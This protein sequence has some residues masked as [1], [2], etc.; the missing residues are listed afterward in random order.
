MAVDS[1]CPDL[2]HLQAFVSGTL[3]QTDRQVLE[4]HLDHCDDCL[5][6]LR[7]LPDS[8]SA[9]R[10]ASRA[11]EPPPSRLTSREGSPPQF[12]PDGDPQRARTRDVLPKVASPDSSRYPF[13]MPAVEPDELGRL[14]NYRVLRLV[15]AGGMGMVFQAEDIALRRPVALK[16]MRPELD[17][18]GQSWKRFLREA[19]T[20]ARIKH[21]HLV[22]VYQ[23][24]QEGETIY[25]AMELLEGETLHEWLERTRPV[26]VAEILRLGREIASGL[27]AIHRQGLVHRDIKPANLWLEGTERRVKI[28]DFGLARG[29]K[30]DTQLTQ[31]GTIMGTPAFMAPEQARGGPVDARSDLFSLGC[32]L[33]YLCSGELPF[34]GANTLAQL[35]ALAVDDPRPLKEVNDAIP[36]E[37]S[38]LVMRLLA[39]KPAERFE[40]AESVAEQLRQIKRAWTKSQRK[41][42]ASSATRK[43]AARVASKRKR[44]GK[45]AL[46]RPYRWKVILPLALVVLTT[47]AVLGIVHWAKDPAARQKERATGGGNV[48]P[49]EQPGEKKRPPQVRPAVEEGKV[50]LSQLQ[51]IAAVHFPSRPGRPQPGEPPPLPGR[52]SVNGNL[53]PHAL[54]MH[55]APPPH[56]APVASASYRLGKQYRTFRTEISLNDSSTQSPSLTFVVYGDDKPLWTFRPVRTQ[57][58][59]QSCTVPVD[60]VNI[61]RLEVMAPA[62]DVFGAH[63][64]WIEPH[65]TK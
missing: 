54:F 39:K 52:L 2:L 29:V 11:S 53:V 34:Q 6:I 4:T 15:G 10:P 40:S 28:L 60:S 55:P 18:D 17:R 58:D 44:T 25:L 20:M 42:N 61:L 38:A 33:Y 19:R 43:V 50:Y 51:E 46:L 64:L 7:T 16:V 5:A 62:G 21:E 31:E 65:V 9:P 47:L 12:Q 27:S 45:W 14:G 23:V 57:A 48:P 41:A 30:D 3:S 37:L 24:G 49:R 26:E 32:V 1:S 13:L 59:A 63:A 36:E 8:P 56:E 35:T 22:T